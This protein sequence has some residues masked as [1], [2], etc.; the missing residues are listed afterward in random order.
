MKPVPRSA[1]VRLFLA[2]LAVVACAIGVKSHGAAA[3]E[4]AVGASASSVNRSLDRK[5]D[6]QR[7]GAALAPRPARIRFVLICRGEGERAI[8]F[9]VARYKLNGDSSKTDIAWVRRTLALRG[10]G[11]DSHG[12]CSLV[13]SVIVCRARVTGMV[14]L[15]GEFAVTSPRCGRG[16]AVSVLRRERCKRRVC[17]DDPGAIVVSSGRPRG[18]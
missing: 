5:A 17:S 14:H 7:A 12:R 4:Q 16:V 3:P 13:G 2:V 6:C 11:A 1:T 10:G 15:E 18:C 8:T 9:Y